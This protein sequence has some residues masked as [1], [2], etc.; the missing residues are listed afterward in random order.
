MAM[1]TK[2]REYVRRVPLTWWLRK[3]PYLT[4]M[5]REITGIFIAAYAVLLVV[6]MQRARVPRVFHA[7][8]QSLGSSRSMDFHVAV[9]CFALFHSVTFFNLTPRV[10]VFHRG[11]DKVPDNAIRA[12]HYLLWL[13]VSA[14]LILIAVRS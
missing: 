7:F 9:L 11:E 13:V 5:V 3:P 12:A 4:F 14:I 2:T 1:P 10:L 6:L 8:Y